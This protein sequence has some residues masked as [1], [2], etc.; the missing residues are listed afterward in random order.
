MKIQVE[1]VSKE[2]T[3]QNDI[4]NKGTE[5]QIEQSMQSDNQE[6][7][8]SEYLQ[9]TVKDTGVGISAAN[10]KKLFQLFGF[11][12]DTSEHNTNGIGLGLVISK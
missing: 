7:E 8:D 1:I 5:K 3:Q 10:Q 11:L 2:K 6:D 4:E 12:S 9:I